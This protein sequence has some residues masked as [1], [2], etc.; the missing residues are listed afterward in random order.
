MLTDSFAGIAPSSVPAFVG[1]QLAGA[2]LAVLIT[3]V[4]AGAPVAPEVEAPS[5]A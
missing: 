2:A 1:A 3:Q 5:D 4:F